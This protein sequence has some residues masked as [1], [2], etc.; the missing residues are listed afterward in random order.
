MLAPRPWTLLQ[1]KAPGRC[2]HLYQLPDG[3]VMF[4]R[5]DL[6]EV[7][8]SQGLS[9]FAADRWQ[10]GVRRGTE[11]HRCYIRRVRAV[12]PLTREE[13]GADDGNRTR[14]FSLGS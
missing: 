2:S 6:L 4:T 10:I 3:R 11:E 14:V 13:T 1:N 7:A 12:V 9:R 5:V 8:G